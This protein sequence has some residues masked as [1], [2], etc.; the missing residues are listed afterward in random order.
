M[1]NKVESV[2]FL[3]I[4]QCLNVVY[5]CRDND[6]KEI[7]P[8]VEYLDNEGQFYMKC[9]KVKNN[10]WLNAGIACK[11]NSGDR[12]EV[13]KDLTKNGTV[14]RCFKSADDGIHYEYEPVLKESQTKGECK[15][16]G[17]KNKYN[18]GQKFVSEDRRFIM[19]C[20]GNSS[21]YR[22]TAVSCLTRDGVKLSPNEQATR[23]GLFYNCTHYDDYGLQLESTVKPPENETEDS[24][25]QSQCF[26]KNGTFMNGKQFITGNFVMR[27]EETPDQYLISPISC[28]IKDGTRLNKGDEVI[29]GDYKFKCSPSSDGTLESL[30]IPYKP[31]K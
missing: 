16:S 28:I 4:L 1:V 20:F 30:R 6:G 23:D 27:C 3:L 9:S 13:G 25:P 11:T 10:K 18:Y 15:D 2:I 17:G 22:I 26:E 7:K 8:D 29:R 31:N 5:A 24:S 19:L 12:L 21:E 14:H